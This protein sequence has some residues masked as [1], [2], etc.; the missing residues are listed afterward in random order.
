MLRHRPVP[1]IAVWAIVFLTIGADYMRAET[2]SEYDLVEAFGS[3]EAGAETSL[4]DVGSAD[5]RPLLGRGWRHD[6]RAGDM[7]YAWGIGREST[8]RWLVTDLRDLRMTFRCWPF[9]SSRQQTIQVS[10]NGKTL[11]RVELDAAARTYTLDLPAGRLVRGW[12]QATFRYEFHRQKTS[13]IAVAWDWVRIE[14]LHD[15]VPPQAGSEAGTPSLLLPAN[16]RVDYHLKL[17]QGTRLVVDGLRSNGNPNDAAPPRLEVRFA[18][19]VDTT[20]YELVREGPTSID[21]PV[22]SPTIIRL[23]LYT[24]SNGASSEKVSWTLLRPRLISSSFVGIDEEPSRTAHGGERPTPRPNVVV[25]LIDTLR[26]DHLGCYGYPKPTSP[27]I[28]A[29]A[30]EATLFVNPVAQSSWTR[31]S[32]A[33]IF[34][35]LGPFEHGTN[36][37]DDALSEE[38]VTIAELLRD[39]GYDTLGLTTNGNVAPAAGFGQGFRRY[40][41][42]GWAAQGTPNASIDLN[43][44]ASEWLAHRTGERP[45]FLYLHTIAPHGPYTPPPPYREQFAP[46]VTDPNIGSG[47]MLKDLFTFRIPNAISLRDDLIALYDA[48]IASDDARFGALV[49]ELKRLDLY[50]SAMI[51]LV[52]DHGEEFADHGWWEHGKTLYQEQLRVPLIV[53]FPHGHGAGRRIAPI[54]QH[55]D[56]LPTILGQAGLTVPASLAGRNLAGLLTDSD[57][58]PVSA[59]SYLNLDGNEIDSVV[60]GGWKL[61]HHHEQAHRGR[62]PEKELF[63][64]SRDPGEQRNLAGDDPVRVGYFETLL[65]VANTGETERMRPQRAVLS[66]SVKE[67]LRALGYLP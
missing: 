29:F 31:A 18:G 19:S 58:G 26:A 8:I 50:D 62:R 60:Q 21:L 54:A 14:P 66:E 6:E 1:S 16:A 3:A 15:A 39:G 36:G 32:V 5:S 12:N 20:T 57:G 47:K 67:Q 65:R 49:A 51:I 48:E 34:T 37:R 27:H 10:V 24:P 33:S 4:I 53:K 17:G 55:I 59:R 28:D 22:D 56:L 41:L 43:Q 52:S 63:D 7:T 45:L 64:L 30:K 11:Q 35:G 2:S 46:H 9:P 38:A 40:E 42:I 13:P 44:Q 61:V 25:F 23:S